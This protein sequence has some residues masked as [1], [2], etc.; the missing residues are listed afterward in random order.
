MTSAR[1][2]ATEPLPKR[3]RGDPLL[4][5]TAANLVGDGDQDV[6]AR[7]ASTRACLN[8]I[9]DAGR[10]CI[11]IVLLCVIKDLRRPACS[12]EVS[13]RNRRRPKK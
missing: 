3:T 6:V 4:A 9:H 12:L 2:E 11:E 1:R 8:M 5:N 10:A 13:L 7:R